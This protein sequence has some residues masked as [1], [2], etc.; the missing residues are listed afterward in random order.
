[1]KLWCIVLTFYDNALSNETIDFSILLK[2]EQRNCSA[3]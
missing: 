3:F 2:A 1:M